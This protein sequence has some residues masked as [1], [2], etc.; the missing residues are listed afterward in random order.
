MISDIF[1]T[2]TQEEEQDDV[3]SFTYIRLSIY[4]IYFHIHIFVFRDR[5]IDR[6]LIYMPLFSRI[7]IHTEVKL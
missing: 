6:Y 7:S 5:Q 1:D 2:S 4:R 3:C